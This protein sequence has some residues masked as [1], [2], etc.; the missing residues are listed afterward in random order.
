MP[1][2]ISTF[3]WSRASEF[4]LALGRRSKPKATE[5]PPAVGADAIGVAAAPSRNV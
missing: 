1:T 5:R 3:R 2:P 4:Q